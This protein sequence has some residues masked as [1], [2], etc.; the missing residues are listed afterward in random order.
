MRGYRAGTKAEIERLHETAR[1][2]QRLFEC[3][4]CDGCGWFEGGPTTCPTCAGHGA[5]VRETV[6]A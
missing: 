3:D 5:L 2:R 1:G 4:D 6:K